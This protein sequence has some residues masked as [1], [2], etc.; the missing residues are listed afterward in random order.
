MLE[1]LRAPGILKKTSSEI[2][3]FFDAVC[4]NM[5]PRNYHNFTHVCD[6]TQFTFT[7]LTTTGMKD[8]FKPIEMVAVIVAAACHDLDHPG[9][10]NVYLTNEKHEFWEKNPESPLEM[11]HYETFEMLVKK[12][13]LLSNLSEAEQT[14]FKSLVKYVILATDMGKHGK[15]VGDVKA[16]LEKKEED[17]L[18]TADGK[19]L[20]LGLLLKTAD[21]SNLSR[22]WQ[23]AAKWNEA[24]KQ[25]ETLTLTPTISP[26]K[27]PTLPLIP[28]LTMT[29]ILVYK[30]FY[31]EGDRD[32]EAGRD[33]NPLHNRETNIIPKS[34]VGFISFVVKPLFVL[35]Q[36]VLKLSATFNPHLTPA[37]M[38]VSLKFLD[39]NV[40]V[41]KKLQE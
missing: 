11:H 25:F 23:V 31:A 3:S 8:S 14:E 19:L 30:E 22:P 27:S 24:G 12:H 35:F 7:L 2:S 34:T 20:V 10:S 40:E 39:D 41:N 1:S 17:P 26:I 33:V 15:T 18:S 28:T 29:P 6:V 37:G 4:S 21:V 9:V 13:A 38:D 5:H 16:I 36:D 32:K